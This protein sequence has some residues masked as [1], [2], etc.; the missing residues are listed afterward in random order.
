LAMGSVFR[1]CRPLLRRLP[2]WSAGAY[3]HWLA[4]ALAATGAGA[5]FVATP[6][7]WWR[8]HPGSLTA[9]GGVPGRVAGLEVWSRWAVNPAFSDVRGRLIRRAG[10]G[11]IRLWLHG[12]ARADELARREASRGLIRMI[13]RLVRAR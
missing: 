3:D 2:G 5:S 4:G 12:A 11:W 13:R 7:S 1:N 10:E 8:T 9:S 6:L